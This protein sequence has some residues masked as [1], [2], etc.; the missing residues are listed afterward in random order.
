MSPL[1]SAPLTCHRLESTSK[2]I[3]PTADMCDLDGPRPLPGQG[4]KGLVVLL[5]Q[6]G[7]ETPQ[8]A[9][10]AEDGVSEDAALIAWGIKLNDIPQ[11]LPANV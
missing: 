8:D 6:L 1:R 2:P 3:L 5:C 7:S 10:R 9:L 11:D 4:R